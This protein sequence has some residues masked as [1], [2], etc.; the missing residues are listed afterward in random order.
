M[1]SPVVFQQGP[2]DII[3]INNQGD[4]LLIDAKTSST[5][6]KASRNT[7]E[8]RYRVRTKLQKKLGVI[9]AYVNK[10]NSIH[11]VPRLKIDNLTKGKT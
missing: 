10:N 6:K 1:F 3:A 11:F 4:M 7:P 5:L 9:V 8:R 2:I